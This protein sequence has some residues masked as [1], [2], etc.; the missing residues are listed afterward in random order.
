LPKDHRHLPPL[1]RDGALALIEVHTELLALPEILPAE[2]VLARSQPIELHGARVRVPDTADQLGHLIGHDRLDASMTRYG[3]FLLRSVFEATLLC[4][5]PSNPRELLARS[6]N[7]PLERYARVG[8][9][10]VARLFPEYLVRPL[11]VS[12]DDNLLARAL[13]GL[14]QIDASGRVRRVFGYG[15]FKLG[16]LVGSP[17]WRK[18]LLTNF[19]SPDYRQYCKHRLR[20]LWS[21]D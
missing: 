20:D 7:T 11:D 9:A 18:H 1:T 5:A 21:G 14:E 3:F 2:L 17:I 12:L 8:L 13:V 4:R 19:R 16:E 15:R 10:L 6:A